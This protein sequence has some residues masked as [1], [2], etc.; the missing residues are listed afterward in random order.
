VKRYDVVDFATPV[1]FV[2]ALRV[3]GSSRLVINA[4]GRLRAARLPVRRPV[5]HRG[6]PQRAP[7]GAG[8]EEKKEYTGERL[9]LNFQDIDVRA[10]LQLLA[11]TAA[12]TSSSPTRCRQRHAAPAERALGPGARHRAAHQ[13]PDDAKAGQRDPRRPAGGDRSREKAELQ[14]KKEVEEL[15]PLRTEYLQVN[16][17]KARDLAT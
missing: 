1:N 7:K 4:T 14:A 8:A 9:T 10:V 12:R 13:G 5:R 15:A 6:P 11:D 16:Y 17:A 3:D 2:D